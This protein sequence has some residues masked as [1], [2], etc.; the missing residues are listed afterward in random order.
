MGF[1]VVSGL[2]AIGFLVCVCA[3][4]ETSSQ[5]LYEGMTCDG[6]V[7]QCD[8]NTL[9]ICGSEG[10]IAYEPCDTICADLGLIYTNICENDEARGHDF[11]QC[12]EEGPCSDGETRCMDHE[13]VEIC[14]QGSWGSVG[15]EDF[16]ETSGTGESQGC[17]I[18]QATGEQACLCGD[19]VASICDTEYRKCAESPINPCGVEGLESYSCKARCEEEELVFDECRYDQEQ[20]ELCRCVEASEEIC[21][22][23]TP[24]CVDETTVT[25]C[26]DGS[27]AQ[28]S[29]ATLCADIGLW[30]LGCRLDTDRGVETCFCYSDGEEVDDTTDGEELEETPESK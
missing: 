25:I 17:A 16:C 26:E 23:Y 15:C 21:G 6:D 19:A 1:R 24:E 18:D 5:D 22:W 20:G 4:S 13:T 12:S 28:V 11:C 8:G 9:K 2:A 14:N 30:S 29:C 10:R 7:F 27:E 3:C